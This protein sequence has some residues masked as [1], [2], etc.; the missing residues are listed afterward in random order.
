VA[1][2]KKGL[3]IIASEARARGK[4]CLFHQR[5]IRQH[6]VEV[7]DLLQ[8]RSIR[9][10]PKGLELKKESFE[11]TKLR[12]REGGADSRLGHRVSPSAGTGFGNV[13]ALED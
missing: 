7:S 11:Q 6:L 8:A 3:L 2:L 9:E 5:K 1:Y 4:G 13:R 12:R 10:E